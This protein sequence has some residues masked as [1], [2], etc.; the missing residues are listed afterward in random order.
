VRL[1]LAQRLLY[2]S[3]TARRVF[4][5]F[6][7][8]KGGRGQTDLVVEQVS[9]HPPITAYRIANASK[10][11][12][13]VGH[14]AQKT[15]FSGG[16]IIVKQVGHAVLTVTLPSGSTE[17]YLITLPRLRIEGI[18]YGKPY[19]ELADSSYISASTGWLASIDYKGKGYF[20]GKA[21][22]FK[23]TLAPAPGAHAKHTYEGEWHT[24]SKET[25]TGAPFHDV[26]A[27]KEEVTT[28]P[29]AEQGEWESRK[30]WEKVAAGI[31]SGDYD[32]AAREK[33]KIEVRAG[34]RAALCAC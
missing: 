9:H 20:S 3:L 34:A 16:N 6:W 7:P 1:Q 33:S 26:S 24:S 30:L 27:P 15:S 5:G 13:L 19:I 4:Y 14:N 12:S 25:K 23:A 11:V 22:S 8:D 17:E 2:A 32:V 31:R 18:W 21:H 28:L 10:G 29:L